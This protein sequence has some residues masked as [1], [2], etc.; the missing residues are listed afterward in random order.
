MGLST[1]TYTYSGSST[2][3]V[4][5]ASG[6]IA[7]ADVQVR[8]NNAVD[9]SGDPVYSTFVWVD[10]DNIT[11]TSALTAGDSVEI[12]R[13]VSKTAL[14]VSFATGADIT[15]ANLDLSANQGL[16]V[17]QELLDG[18]VDGVES[19]VVAA[20]RAETAALAA[21]ADA[22]LT[23]ADAVQTNLDRTAAAA[24]AAVAQGIADGTSF[25]QDASNL[26]D[27]S[28][29]PAARTNLG[30][31]I[32]TNVQAHDATLTSLAGIDD[33]PLSL[34]TAVLAHLTSDWETGGATAPGLPSPANI[35]AAIAALSPPTPA[36]AVQYFARSTAPTGYLKANGAAVSRTTYSALFTAI[37]STFGVGDGSTTFNVP[38][39]RG[40]FVRGWDDARGID[41]SRVF[42]S[43]QADEIKAHAHTFYPADNTGAFTQGFDVDTAAAG[44]NLNSPKTTTSTGGTE[45]RPRNI[46][47]LACIS[48]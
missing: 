6:F 35:A 46:A 48:Y 15:P 20:N 21:E 11:V 19:P 40:E 29:K 3:V 9:G 36:G 31:E 27:L 18:R 26:S 24:S 43:A 37:G 16:M 2:F 12:L 14:A 41:V 1:N 7:R 45:T 47:L 4:N 28:D 10:D 42:G 32:G 25:L 23:A 38:D 5:F 30:V 34:F 22:A 13:T 8:I 17:Y 33:S 39:L 44:G